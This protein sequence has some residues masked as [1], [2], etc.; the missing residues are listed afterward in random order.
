[1]IRITTAA[2][3]EEEKT[4]KIKGF[5]AKVSLVKSRT[6]EA[7]R[8]RDFV[9]NQVEGF[10][11]D[12]TLL[13]FIKA[14]GYLLGAGVSY[15]LKG[16]ETHTFNLGNFKEK[17]KTDNELREYFYSIGR[18]LLEKSLKVSTKFEV[19]EPEIEETPEE[20]SGIDLDE[21]G[22]GANE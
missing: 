17:L 18:E 9:Y 12:L 1:M 5:M 6:A 4:Y 20:I 22:E 21:E 8:S 16:L 11:N 14:N 13:E 15:K 2:K 19:K 3:L 7:G 10:D